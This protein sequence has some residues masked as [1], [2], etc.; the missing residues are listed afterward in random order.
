MDLPRQAWLS[1]PTETEP[2]H[3]RVLCLTNRSSS[4]LT[5]HLLVYDFGNL[6]GTDGSKVIHLIAASVAE[7]HL[8]MEAI[9]HLETH[10]F[11]FPLEYAYPMYFLAFR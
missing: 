3:Q 11:H 6:V 1:E 8:R 9:I 7:P 4:F 5:L 2:Q 10:V